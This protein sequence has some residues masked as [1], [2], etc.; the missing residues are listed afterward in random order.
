LK[1]SA[2]SSGQWGWKELYHFGEQLIQEATLDR[3]CEL[4]H[5]ILNMRIQAEAKLWLSEIFHPLPGETIPDC[6]DYGKPSEVVK[7]SI[8]NKKIFLGKRQDKIQIAAVPLFIHNQLI[9]AIELTFNSKEPPGQSILEFLE[10]FGAH[11][12]LALSISRQSAVKDWRYEQLTLLRQVNLQIARQRED[13]TVFQNVIN[14]IQQAF[15]YYFVVLYAF[16]PEDHRLHYRSSNGRDNAKYQLSEIGLDAEISLGKGLVGRAAKLKKEI[17]SA[18]VKKDQR[19]RAVSGLPGTCSEVCLPLMIEGRLLGV[20]DV[21]SDQPEGFH[22]NDLVVLRILADNVA[23]AL[24]GVQMVDALSQRAHQ[25]AAVTEVSRLLVSILDFDELLHKIVSIVHEQF[26]YPFV[27][28]FVM[29][30]D[31]ERLVFEAGTGEVSKTLTEHKFSLGLHDEKSIVS[32]VAR[33]GCTTIANDVSLEPL[34]LENALPPAH[35]RSEMAVP[36]KYGEQVL[37][38]LDIQSDR[39]NSF[40]EE[41]RFILEVLAASISTALRNANLYRS[42]SWRR[43]VAESYKEIARLFSTQFTLEV[44]YQA[45]LKELM[46]NLPCD[47]AAIW[48]VKP[49]MHGHSGSLLD[50]ACVEGLDTEKVRTELLRDGKLTEWLLKA[51]QSDQPLIRKAGEPVEPLGKALH[52]PQEYSAIAAPLWTTDQVFGLIV[53]TQKAPN[54]YGI[55]AAAMLATFAGYIS[56]AIQNNQLYTSSVE[57]AWIST[58]MLQVSEAAQSAENAESLLKSI[59]RITPLLI[60]VDQCA[61]FIL[62]KYSSEYQLMAQEGF[63]KP[64]ISWL[65]NLPCSADGK[66]EFEKVKIDC[67]VVR[68]KGKKNSGS[69]PSDPLG[70]GN[71]QYLLLPLYSRK[72]LFG[73][74][75]VKHDLTGRDQDQAKMPEDQRLN[76]LQGIARQTALVLENIQ[77]KESGQSEGYITAV[78]LQVAQTVASSTDLHETFQKVAN[79]LPY[80]VGVDTVLVYQLDQEKQI[81]NLR[82]SFSEKWT[83]EIGGLDRH[84]KP[85]EY[86]LL[87]LLSNDKKPI[88]IPNGG[89]TPQ[90]WNSPLDAQSIHKSVAPLGENPDILFALPLLVRN[91]LFGALL[92][93][94]SSKNFAFREKRFEIIREVAQQLAMAAQA[95]RLTHE[96]VDNERMKREMQL[97]NEIQR[98]FLPDKLP[99]IPGWEVDVHW[100]PAR[101]V[102]GDFYDAFQLPDGR[103]GFVIADVSDKG[104]PAALYMT[105]TRTLVHASAMNAESPAKTLYQVNKLLMENSQEG[106]FTTVFYAQIDPQTG[107]MIYCNAGHNRPGWLKAKEKNVHW[108][109]KGG[110]ALGGFAEID[111]CDSRVSLKAGD[112]MVL[113]TDGVSEARSSRDQLF[114]VTRLKKFLAGQIGIPAQEL[115]N[116]LDSELSAFR[117]AQPQSDDITVMAIRRLRTH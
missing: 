62:D 2:S 81:F 38:V 71:N 17:V 93:S 48:I 77:L 109:E 111:L 104:I 34:Y 52:L 32:Y 73:V 21:Q 65:K 79:I 72:E 19:Y 88:F 18:N 7:R 89:V 70:K 5:S 101:Q 51:L 22:E 57:Q 47:A 60:G 63:K 107:E 11:C 35:T 108:L 97:A 86:P 50:L 55:D 24:E 31:N 90:S 67:P 94:E 8:A 114:G 95:D 54:R 43:Q 14:L 37:G 75:L 13:A 36:L 10:S 80:L 82:G 96:M 78:L 49:N 83:K 84:V 69:D 33:E 15:H 99:I 61:F 56:I 44:V 115:L 100:H 98:T 87:D 53:L 16:D 106:L 23:A 27:H 66:K 117:Q 76:V 112:C 3:Q 45:I 30:Q 28:C 29:D 74:F 6:V 105:V 64:N 1:P 113:Y 4:I 102:S 26:N 103:F 92:V 25:L 46:H 68:L 116:D 9:G 42:E 40:A 12:A 20:L 39:V 110:T 91:E 58:V 41:D 85:G 59:A